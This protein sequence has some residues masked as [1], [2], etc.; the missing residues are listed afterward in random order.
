MQTKNAKFF[1][2]INDEILRYIKI[3]YFNKPK[4]TYV[5]STIIT[6]FAPFVV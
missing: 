6:N 5:I 1:S 2:E 4:N 3:E